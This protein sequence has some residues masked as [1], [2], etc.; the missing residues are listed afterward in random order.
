MAWLDRHYKRRWLF[1]C[2]CWNEVVINLSSI[3]RWLTKSC[4]CFRK[5][6]T[7]KK[8]TTHW[9]THRPIHGIW[10]WMRSRCNNKNAQQ[11]NDY[12]WRW[13][14]IEWKSFDEF[15]NDMWSSYIDWYSIERK[16]VNWNYCKDNCIW[17]PRC[18]QAYNTRNTV[19]VMVDWKEKC[20]AEVCKDRWLVYERVRQRITRLG[21][22]VEDAL[23]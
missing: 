23:Y 12:W 16:D 7:K 3:K 10:T 15:Y 9:M 20:L 17:I 13:I 19:R 5:E 18:E 6:V 2:I 11:Y 21:W 14:I 8:S 1:R 22:K 4:W